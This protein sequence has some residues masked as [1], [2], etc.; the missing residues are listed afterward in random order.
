MSIICSICGGTDIM[1]AAVVDPNTK[2]FLDFGYEAFLDGI[3]EQCGNVPLTDPDEVQADIE[4][5]WAEHLAK[6][7]Q[8]PRYAY[9]GIVQLNN[10]GME[11]RFIRVGKQMQPEPSCKVF[12]CCDNLACLK[13]FTVPGL[14]SGREFT[15]VSIEALTTKLP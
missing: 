12:A 6:Y 10:E 5:L 1:C 14:E 11:R 2:E 3:C 4:K 7:G 8:E 13:S 9:C 15:V